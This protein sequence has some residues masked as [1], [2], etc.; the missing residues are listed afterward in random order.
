MLIELGFSSLNGVHV[1]KEVLV[2]TGRRT[3]NL[4]EDMHWQE[5]VQLVFQRLNEN[6]RRWVAALFSGAVGHG[7]Q[8]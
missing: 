5:Q 6:Q 1:M 4:S 8:K 2:C 3:R 7:G